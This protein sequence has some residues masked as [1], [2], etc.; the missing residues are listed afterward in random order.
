MAIKLTSN[1]DTSF[2]NVPFYFDNI[3]DCNE[4]LYVFKDHMCNVPWN[5]PEQVDSKS[6]SSTK[7]IQNPKQS[8]ER[9]L[10]WG[11]NAC[12][13]TSISETEEQLNSIRNIIK[14]I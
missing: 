8:A 14:S 10:S 2:H 4:F 1:F 7:I 13:F 9:N 12:R 3:D 6:I 5:K 11:F